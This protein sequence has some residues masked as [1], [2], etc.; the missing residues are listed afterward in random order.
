MKINVKDLAPLPID[1][2]P[3]DPTAL[4]EVVPQYFLEDLSTI[5]PQPRHWLVKNVIPGGNSFTG[6]CGDSNC[7]KTF[8]LFDIMFSLCV[9][10][11]SWQ[12]QKI[13]GKPEDRGLI[14]YFYSEGLDDVLFRLYAWLQKRGYTMEDLGGRFIPLNYKAFIDDES[15]TNPTLSD[16]N[17][18]KQIKASLTDLCKRRKTHIDMIALDTLNGWMGG[19]EDSAKDMSLFFG[20]LTTYMAAPFNA[21]IVIVHHTGLIAEDKQNAREI[22]PRG[23]SAFRARLDS[24]IMCMG[25]IFEK[26][27]EVFNNK[28]RAGKRG[29]DLYVKAIEVVIDCVPL[30]DEGEPTTSLV[31]DDSLSSDEVKKIFDK[32]STTE[33]NNVTPKT[34]EDFTALNMGMNKKEL[35]YTLL[36]EEGYKDEEG[37]PHNVYSLK[38]EAVKAWLRDFYF[39]KKYEESG[40]SESKINQT[41]SKELA[42]FENDK[43]SA[44]FIGRLYKAGIVKFDSLENWSVMYTQDRYGDGG[45]NTITWQVIHVGFCPKEKED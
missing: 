33:K 44:R 21:S 9:G 16:S 19:D 27:L 14:V 39:R 42:I 26:G 37:Y 45:I 28:M 11:T 3:A 24:L 43:I 30:D 1:R 15:I 29:L 5:K 22:R 6:I 23:S 36:E 35:P 40:Y 12:G 7:G 4:G 31:I 25:N 38:R 2:E 18:C 13:Y 8:M 41:L 20:N 34:H 17:T 32:A 10:R